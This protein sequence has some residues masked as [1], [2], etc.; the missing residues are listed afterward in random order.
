MKPKTLVR[1]SWV[2]VGIALLAACGGRAATTEA[3][4]EEDQRVTSTLVTPHKAWAKPYAKGRLR[5]LFVV[6]AGSYGGGW[7]APGTRLREVTEL[8]QRFDL[9]AD[10]FFYGGRKKNEF[11]GEG[12]GRKRAE[13]LLSKPYDVYV[14]AGANLAGLPPKFQYL[15]MK[16]VANG[17]GLVCCGAGSKDFMTDSR[18]LDPVPG[19]LTQG[20]PKLDDKGP[21]DV[22]RAYRLGK[23]RGVWMKYAAWTLTPRNVFSWSEL[24]LYDYRMLWVGRALLWA[25][26]KEP[27]A[28][29]SFKLDPG[30]S[31]LTIRDGGSRPVT[32]HGSVSIR[33]I[34]DGW[35]TELFGYRARVTQDKP[36]QRAITLPPLRAGRYMIDTVARSSKGVAAFAAKDF[37]VE[38]P[39]G[40]ERVALDRSFAEVGEEIRGTVRLRGTPPAGSTL[41]IDFR[42]SYNRVR[43]HRTIP[44]QADTAE[45][46]F[47]YT[48]DTFATIWMRA[49]AV[50]V[51]GGQE[52]ELREAS[53]TVPK[54]RRGRFNF[55]QWDTPSDV[56]GYYAWQQMGDAGMSLCLL[57]SFSESAFHPVLA[58][59]DVPLVPYT[60]RILDP[61]DEN[62][63]MKLRPPLVKPEAKCWNDEPAIDAYV[64]NIARC[65]QKRREHGVYCYSLGDEGVT[66]GCCVH[67]AGLKAY[68]AWLKKQYGDIATL[69]ASWDAKYEDFSAVDLLDHKDNMETEALR[70]GLWARWYDRQAFAR[71]NL[72]RFSK[73]FGD[74]YRKLDPRA[75]TGFEG[76]GR[77]GDDYDAIVG[78][79][80]FYGPYPSIGDDI[81]RSLAPRGFLRSNWMGYSKTGDALSDA[82]WR[83]VIKGMDSIWFWMWTGI[84]TYRGYVT[85]TLDLYPATA[86]LAREMKPVREGLGDLLLNS[87]M[88]HSGIAILYSLPSALA[89]R[90]EKAP[91]FMKPSKV[92]ETW[93]DLIYE[94][95]LDFRYVTDGMLRTGALTTDEFKVL[96]L[97]TTMAL[98]PDQAETI[99][100]YV[101]AGGHVI[102]DVRP[103]V[104]DG[105]CKPL[106]KGSLDDLFGFRRMDRGDAR[107]APVVLKGALGGQALDVS[108]PEA[109]IDAGIET[110]AA[111]AFGQAGTVPLLLRH[112][113]GKGTATLLNFQLLSGKEDPAQL[114]AARELVGALLNESGVSPFVTA[115]APDG[116]VL[117]RTEMRV[118][119]NGDGYVFGLW[120]RMECA[121]F[122]PKSGTT[123]GTPQ[124][125]RVTLEAPRYVYDLRQGKYLG[126]VSEFDTLLRWGRANFF[127]ALPY[128]IG[129]LKMTLSSRRPAPGETL[130]VS[131]SLKVPASGAARHAV[132]IELTGPD[133]EPARWAKQ[134]VI[135][136]HGRATVRLPVA[137]NDASGTW[138][139]RATELFSGEH[140]QTKWNLRR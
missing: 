137:F 132:F 7:F 29:V 110:T 124:P 71:V 36:F 83:M 61:K 16:E 37:E 15:I 131:I 43:A 90:I 11:L 31:A 123:A 22:M 119:R 87:T 47:T 82:A 98:A 102:A 21:A 74:A 114:D 121:W 77:F 9:E 13:K 112:T 67:P 100:R 6:D 18:R 73:R 125:A 64:E 139:L 49:Q 136:E 86:D 42:D 51:A 56:L 140:T 108:F 126:K 45:Y 35:T 68:R 14:I 24:A 111:N 115:T 116:G 78:M 62:G 30:N 120:R 85:P 26:A 79:N 88:T 34:S 129:R 127:L 3:E 133:G 17:A 92:H 72:A 28:A 27:V 76:T 99:R 58:A 10:A 32:L 65:Q 20:L 12:L 91:S 118:W 81:V 63:F 52:V 50:L 66:K 122:N 60:T 117:P 23:G 101:E 48:P 80:G 94:L 69:N 39:F 25:A 8:A 4:V 138:R 113:L 93:A 109:R 1:L 2:W 75:I 135:L 59:A 96:L 54:R 97:P 134:V 84:G 40:V 95:G 41:R 44:V 55:L 57:G 106:E 70:Q 33:R 5:A 107:R 38:K 19:S 46:A 105:H 89:H 128:R 104:F 103:G 53:F 130:E